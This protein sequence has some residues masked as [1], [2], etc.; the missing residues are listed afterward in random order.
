VAQAFAHDSNVYRLSDQQATPASV[1]SRSDTI[2]TTSLVAGID[3][4]VGRQR[5]YASARLDA[6]RYASNDQLNNN[7]FALDGGWD[8]AT[9]NRLS[10][11]IA[12]GSR[13]NLRAFDPN[14]TLGSN[15]QTSSY[16]SVL[17]RI[18][19]VTRLTAQASVNWRDVSYSAANYASAEY[20]QTGFGLGLRYRLG[21]STT[22][23][24]D[25]STTGVHYNRPGDDRRRDEVNLTMDWV[26]GGNT[27]LNGRIGYATVDPDLSVISGFSGVTADIRALWQATGK[28]RVTTRLSRDTGQDSSFLELANTTVSSTDFSR[29]T[30][31]LFLGADYALSS[32][33]GIN[34]GVSMARRDLTN[35]QYNFLLGNTTVNGTDTTTALNVGARWTPWRSV[36][37]GCGLTYEKRTAS[38]TVSLP[39]NANGFSCYGQFTLR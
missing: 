27:Q 7:G 28:I 25:A 20:D 18:G 5:F 2:S 29:T 26:P 36:L 13:R 19:V 31:R 12:I 3:Q 35:S 16:A 11:T 39:Y 9:I 38:S 32:K 30:T 10:G 37:L 22:V 34:A 21:G 8:W 14:E 17:G 1:K 24:I 15:I 33:I 4:P 6:N 23:G